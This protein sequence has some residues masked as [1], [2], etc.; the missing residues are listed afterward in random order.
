MGGE[1][2]HSRGIADVIVAVYFQNQVVGVLDTVVPCQ[3][4]ILKVSKDGS[5]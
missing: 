1:L 5:W 2:S 3:F 4:E